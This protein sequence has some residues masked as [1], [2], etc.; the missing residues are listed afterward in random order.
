MPNRK[1]GVGMKLST[2]LAFDLGASSGRALVGEMIAMEGECPKLAVKEIYRFPNQV[3]HA[4]KRMHWDI[5]TV[6]ARSKN[7]YP[8]SVPGRFSTR[9]AR[10]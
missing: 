6:A 7:R 4:G 5:I 3:V 2:V 8:T 9:Y 10:Y 1:W